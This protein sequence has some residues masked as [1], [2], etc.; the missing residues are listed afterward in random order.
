[1]YRAKTLGKGR[2]A[3]FDREMYAQT[4]Y[5][6]QL[7]TDLRLALERQEFILYYQPIVSL[8]TRSLAGFEALVRW[9]HPQ[10]GLISPEKFIA[11]AEGV[12]TSHQITHLTNLGCSAAQGYFFAKPL[13]RQLVESLIVNNPQW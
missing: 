7:E 9:Q 13:N 2:Y 8:E 5:L 12:E 11:I 4:I 6:S 10:I 3:V 1:M